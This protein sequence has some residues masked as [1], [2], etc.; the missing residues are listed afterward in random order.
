MNRHASWWLT[1]DSGSKEASEARREGPILN[2][3]RDLPDYANPPVIEVALSIQFERLTK[4]RAAYLG[5]LWQEY[6]ANFPKTEEH[7]PRDP[8]VESFGA[9]T[10]P[11]IRVEVQTVMPV[12]RVWFV[13]QPG[14]QLIQV[15]QDCFVH[16]WRKV[17]ISTE[18]YPRYESIRRT[19][20]D[21]L[22]T[23]ERFLERE[24]LGRITPFQAEITYVNHIIAGDGWQEL[25]QIDRIFSP[26]SGQHSDDFLPRPEQARIAVGY[27]MRKSGGEPVGRLHVDLVP[28]VDV[29]TQT[30]MVVLTLTARGKPTGPGMEGA[31]RFLDVGRE[32]IVR[33]FAS[34]TTT[35]MD[36][37]WRRIDAK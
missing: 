8:V 6:R 31:L 11:Q 25:G 21:E 29:K 19:F 18:V 32:W 13:N 10:P 35:L 3:K 1:M 37:V 7:P 30:P 34:I 2:A 27:L 15:Q 23:F 9:F 26:W 14:T 17:G 22:E 12:P 5:L 36:D 28:A 20:Q 4:L 16:N 24:E 33:G